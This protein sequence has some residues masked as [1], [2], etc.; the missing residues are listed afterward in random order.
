M[1]CS[2]QS[3]SQLLAGL[4]SE[5][6]CF[7]TRFTV[8]SDPQLH[9]D[10]VG[11]VSLPITQHM[12]HRLCA[13]AQP[14]MHGYKDQT[15]LDPGVRDTWEIPASCIRMESPDWQAALEC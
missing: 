13:V 12:A 10:G 2:A 9:I 11:S 8:S 6:E 14:A 1:S 5:N 3:I 15:L 4:G 7:A